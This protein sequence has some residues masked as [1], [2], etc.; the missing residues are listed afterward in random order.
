MYSKLLNNHSGDMNNPSGWAE[1]HQDPS[2]K[3]GAGTGPRPIG[4]MGPYGLIRPHGAQ[5]VAMTNHGLV[6]NQ[7]VAPT[8]SVLFAIIFLGLRALV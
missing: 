3:I 1:E 6:F 7:T 5:W 8:I 4:P 2:R